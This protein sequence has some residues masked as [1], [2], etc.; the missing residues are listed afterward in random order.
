[1]DTWAYVGIWYRNDQDKAVFYKN[2]KCS[3]T[4]SYTRLM[5]RGEAAGEDEIIDK[6][7][8]YNRISS[9]K[10]SNSFTNI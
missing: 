9:N 2:K 5:E 8:I 7:V 4:V 10:D 1:M 3:N 6:L